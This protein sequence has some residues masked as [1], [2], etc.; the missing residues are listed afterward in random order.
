MISLDSPSNR[1]A[2]DGTSAWGGATTEQSGEAGPQPKHESSKQKWRGKLG[3]L[4][5]HIQTQDSRSKQH[6]TI[7]AFLNP[8]RIQLEEEEAK[9]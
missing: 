5:V 7:T 2:A 9:R 3:K 6:Q 1:G 8:T 4:Q